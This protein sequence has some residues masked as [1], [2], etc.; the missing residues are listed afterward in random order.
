MLLRRL[1]VRKKLFLWCVILVLMGR[2]LLSERSFSKSLPH[3]EGAGEDGLSDDSVEVH[4][5]D[6]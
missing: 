2:S 5:H 1:T 3:S 4:Y 6:L